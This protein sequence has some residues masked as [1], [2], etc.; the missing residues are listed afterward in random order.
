MD[1][2]PAR[3]PSID[4]LLRS[5]LLTVQPLL[6]TCIT[7]CD[8]FEASEGIHC[9]RPQLPHFLCKE[10]FSAYVSLR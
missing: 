4:E 6:F 7:C 1:A 10:D 5:Q 8:D 2:E 9:G 3:R